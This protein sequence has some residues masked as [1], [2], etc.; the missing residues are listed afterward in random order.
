MILEPHC[1]EWDSPE[2]QE[3]P[4]AAMASSSSSQWPGGDRVRGQ[5]IRAG[6]YRSRRQLQL[7]RAH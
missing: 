7:R 2:G 4:A 6:N 3:K 5:Q 1:G